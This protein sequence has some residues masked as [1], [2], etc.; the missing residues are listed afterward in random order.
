MALTTDKKLMVAV[1]VLAVLGGAVYMQNKKQKEEAATYTAEKRT[2]DLPKLEI[3]EEQ[4]K[5]V[6]KIVL[7]KPRATPARVS[8]SPSRRRETAGR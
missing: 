8:M 3:S 7:S 2:A 6:D 1:G 5:S 4:T